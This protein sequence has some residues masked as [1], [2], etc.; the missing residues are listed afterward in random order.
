M[1]FSVTLPIMPSGMA[2]TSGVCTSPESSSSSPLDLERDLRAA[3]PGSITFRSSRHQRP[4]WFPG[5]LFVRAVTVTVSS[6]RSPSFFVGVDGEL[7]DAVPGRIHV[8]QWGQQLVVLTVS[9]SGR[10]RRL[11]G[12]HPASS[13]AATVVE[14]RQGHG[15][16]NGQGFG[17]APLPAPDPPDC[18][19]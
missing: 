19:R 18:L 11:L 16:G 7:L 15:E 17:R 10:E 12:F 5:W 8:P 1:T 6:N 14:R 3:C 13:G 9:P 2:S 4:S